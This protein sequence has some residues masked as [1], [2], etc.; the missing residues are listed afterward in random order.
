VLGKTVMV[1]ARMLTVVGVLPSQ[2]KLRRW[3]SAKIWL[4]LPEQAVGEGAGSGGVSIIAR[5]RPGLS[6]GQA[7]SQAKLAADRLNRERP[8]RW[9]WM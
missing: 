6:L 1:D 7:Q 8:G 4:P 3:T 9:K 2:F 5:L